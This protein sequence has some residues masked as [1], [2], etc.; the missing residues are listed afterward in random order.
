MNTKQFIYLFALVMLINSPLR[1]QIQMPQASPPSKVSQLVGLTQVTLEYSRPSVRERK[2][3]GELVPFGQVW[4]TGANSATIIEFSTDVTVEG[5]PLKA[6]KY[7]LYSIPEK[8][9]STIVF[10]SK[11]DLWGAVG[12]SPSDDVLR[13]KAT[14]K[15][16]KRPIETLEIGFRDITD[17]G[18][19]LF[20][21][22]EK[23]S[24]QLRIK[25][26]VDPLV[27]NQI[28]AH[29]IDKTPDNPGIYFQAAT[30]YFNTDRD[31]NLAL[32]WVTKSVEADP[33]YWTV[34]LKAKIEQKLNMKE[35]AKAS[36]TKSMEMAKEANNL[37]Y[38][39]LNERLI[40]ALK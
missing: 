17:S 36:A 37:D 23:V 7:A 2:I 30:Y 5:Q 18:A 22:W 3:F 28:Q 15:K 38:V 20:I 21:D 19:S 6:G 4:R 11:T 25:S 10:S 13:V 14:S 31:L 34:H 35:E 12:Y 33:K 27:M 9:A 39:G 29:V 1:A 16:L 40:K 8:N 24:T 26:E 32:D